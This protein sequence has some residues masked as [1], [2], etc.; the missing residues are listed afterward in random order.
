MQWGIGYSINKFNNR[1]HD[2]KLGKILVFFF[3]V[4]INFFPF[5]ISLQDMFS[6]IAHTPLKVK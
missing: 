5:E 3:I 1:N 4:G 6:E 2:Y